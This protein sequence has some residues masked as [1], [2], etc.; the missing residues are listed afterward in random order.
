VYLLLLPIV[1]ATVA[2]LL[3]VGTRERG[4]WALYALNGLW[5]CGLV[6]AVYLSALAWQGSAHSE[7]W[8]MYGVIFFVWPYSILVTILGGL[9][10]FLLRTRTDPH[11]T[12]CRRL[13]CLIIVVLLVL[14]A[15]TLLQAH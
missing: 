8:A 7:N 10:V 9:E 2:G 15:S 12:R 3:T 13:T 14:S 6:V 11:A 4:Y 5:L 1:F